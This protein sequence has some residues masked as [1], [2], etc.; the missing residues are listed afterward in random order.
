MCTSM[1]TLMEFQIYADKIEMLQP[2]SQMLS[3]VDLDK[4]NCFNRIQSHINP[5]TLD[6][7]KASFQIHPI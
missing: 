7:P 3:E 5:W 6:A 1:V 4:E 2:K